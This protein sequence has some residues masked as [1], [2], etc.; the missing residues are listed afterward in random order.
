MIKNL[1][2]IVV[3]A[4]VFAFLGSL[5]LLLVRPG[6]NDERSANIALAGWM[7]FVVG[8]TTLRVFQRKR[9]AREAREREE[10]A[11]SDVDSESLSEES[12]PKL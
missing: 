1:F 4:Y 5:V 8:L 3:D 7:L 6:F 12:E 2:R 11:R 9:I 10:Q